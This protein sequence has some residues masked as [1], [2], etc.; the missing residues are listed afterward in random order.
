[1]IVIE[2]MANNTKKTTISLSDDTKKQL[3]Q[4]EKK[5]GESFDEILQRVM[6][7]ASTLC[8]KTSDNDVDVKDDEQ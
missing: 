5:K 6:T 2:L 3:A 7:N 1:M 8:N 4:F